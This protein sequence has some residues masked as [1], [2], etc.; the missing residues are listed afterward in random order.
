[1]SWFHT[2]SEVEPRSAGTKQRYLR[3]YRDCRSGKTT[4]YAEPWASCW[5][6]HGGK[7]DDRWCSPPQ[8]MYWRLLSDLN[9]G[10]SHIAIYANDLGVAI[11]GTY[12]QGGRVYDDGNRIYQ[13]EFDAAIRFS[14]MIRERATLY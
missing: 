12:R 13:R 3:F 14:G 2:S 6:H 5:G 1:M 7:T 10:V 8:W 11:D 4:A 9:C